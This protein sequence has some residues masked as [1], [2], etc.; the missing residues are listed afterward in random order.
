MKLNGTGDRIEAASYPLTTQDLVDEHGDQKIEHQGGTE[1]L[2]EVL[3]RSE[4]EEYHSPDDV[5]FTIY[6]CVDGDA[7]GRRGYCDRDPTPPGVP[8][9]QLSF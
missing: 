7:V 4:A 9:D 5:L 3:D 6:S 2:A 1:R 8:R